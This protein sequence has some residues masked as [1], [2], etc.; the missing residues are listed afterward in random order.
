MNRYLSVCF[1][2]ISLFSFNAYCAINKWVDDSGQVHY[3]DQA[4][5]E[6][7]QSTSIGSNSVAAS[8]IA[9]SDVSA[10]KSLAEREADLKKNRK[11]KA[12]AEQKAA[13][14]Q[15]EA[16]ARQKYCLDTRGTLK[17]L[18][19]SPRIVTY[20]ADGNRSYLDGAARQQRIQETRE[21]IDANCSE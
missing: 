19:E 8:A 6:D 7:T 21:A 3:S 9:A 15:K 17:S 4:P 2:M 5:P 12:G 11:T 10:P 1:L 13:K 16:D 14:Q 18:E 20:D